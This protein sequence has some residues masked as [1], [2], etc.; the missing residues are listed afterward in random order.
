VDL[1]FLSLPPFNEI[2]IFIAF[3]LCVSDSG[4]HSN[5]SIL[6]AI[7]SNTRIDR[8]LLDHGMDHDI[9]CSRNTRIDTLP[10]GQGMVH[11]I[12]CSGDIISTILEQS[13]S[14]DT[15]N[16]N[17]HNSLKESRNLIWT[18]TLGIDKILQTFCEHVSF[19]KFSFY[20]K[21]RYVSHWVVKNTLRKY[22]FYAFSITITKYLVELQSSRAITRL[23]II[24]PE[25]NVHF[26]C[27]SWLYTHMPNIKSIC[28]QTFCEHVSFLKYFFL[29]ET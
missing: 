10:L 5:K 2:I 25:R 18:A 29:H 27:I 20:I 26:I 16:T 6:T 17:A 19:L 22:Y 12:S 23:N 11:E 9:F 24:V 28:L 14:P 3:V 13:V 8:L 15:H 21:L 4:L 7:E 1:L